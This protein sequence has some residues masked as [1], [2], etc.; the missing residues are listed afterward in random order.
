MNLT[1]TKPYN[2]TASVVVHTNTKG[3]IKMTKQA[4]TCYTVIL[5]EQAGS[6]IGIIKRGSKGYYATNYEYGTGEEAEHA[7]RTLNDQR[8]VDAQ[9]QLKMEMGSMF[10]WND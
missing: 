1:Q 9:E 8:G 5:T 10:G 7:V 4:D 3:Y 2:A 6:N